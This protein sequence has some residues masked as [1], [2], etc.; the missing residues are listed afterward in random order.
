M[1][2]GWLT[3]STS[4]VSDADG[5]AAAGS[6]EVQ[7]SVHGPQPE[8]FVCQ[9]IVD[10]LT[11]R[12]RVGFFWTADDPDNPRPDAW[13]AECEERVLQTDGEWVGE[14]LDLLKPKILCGACYDLAK[15]FHTG[16]NPW[17]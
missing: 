9:H 16:S 4:K 17:S 13:C 2:R 3:G 14:A 10:G 6:H 11:R 15:A 12:D 1:L 7:C 5:H 8:T